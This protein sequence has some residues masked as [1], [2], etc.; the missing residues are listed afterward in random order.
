MRESQYLKRLEKTNWHVLMK[1]R[2]KTTKSEIRA[3]VI[4][5]LRK[6]TYWLKVGL[7]KVPEKEIS[8]VITSKVSD[9]LIGLMLDDRPRQQRIV[10][11]AEQMQSTS[12]IIYEMER[13]P[14]AS[15]KEVDRIRALKRKYSLLEKEYHELTTSVDQRK[16]EIAQSM[17]YS[18]IDYVVREFE[19]VLGGMANAEDKED[20]ISLRRN[21]EILARVVYKIPRQRAVNEALKDFERKQNEKKKV[22][23]EV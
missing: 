7:Q 13:K 4:D 20:A 6:H 19:N 12:S 3:G 11:V 17:A 16:L 15:K 5:Q 2:T 9:E 21:Q 1:H 14:K 18:G 10:D 22:N 8:Q 23:S